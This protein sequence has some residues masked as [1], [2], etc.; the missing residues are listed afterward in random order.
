MRTEELSR[1][2]RPTRAAPSAPSQSSP[3]GILGWSFVELISRPKSERCAI[4]R[5]R[6]LA[7]TETRQKGA[8]FAGSEA[9][10][11]T[12]RKIRTNQ[13]LQLYIQSFSMIQIID[14]FTQLF[15]LRPTLFRLRAVPLSLFS[16]RSLDRFYLYTNLT[17]TVHS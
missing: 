16:R 7:K 11:H 3:T 15:P 10:N 6:S 13:N 9:L 1:W 17:S 8:V 12:R 14:R 5:R 4:W 2:Q